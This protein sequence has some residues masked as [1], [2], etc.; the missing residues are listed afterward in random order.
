MNRG[1]LMNKLLLDE[2][3]ILIL[4]QLAT[5]IGLNE[6]IVL[7]QVHYWIKHNEASNRN[8]KEGHYWVYNTFDEW[9]KQF[10]FWSGRTIKRTF[11][12]LE[13]EK[14]LI[15]GHYNKKSYDRTKWYRIDYK[16]LETLAS[17]HSDKMAQCIVTNWHNG[18]GQNGTMDSDKM[19]PP[20]PETNSETT[21]K[22]NYIYIIFEHWNK[23]GI[24]RH[25]EFTQKRKSAINAR[26]EKY[27]VDELKEA[28]NNYK[29]VLDSPKHFWTHKW[30]LEQF[31]NPTNIERFT[32]DARPLEEFIKN[33]FKGTQKQFIPMD[34]LYDPDKDAF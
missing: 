34:E 1:E 27:S 33:E 4:P 20:I 3:P 16:R 5:I 2:Q 31:M 32:N 26:L 11:K 15:V 12:K 19:T 30:T 13:D 10:P 6:S 25:R 7:Q 14:L 8:H 29:Y 21:T 9:E 17:D 23:Q 18:K 24:I 22:T 28:I